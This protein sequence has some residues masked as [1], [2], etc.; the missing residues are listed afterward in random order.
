[1]PCRGLDGNGYVMILG[2]AGCYFVLNGIS[3]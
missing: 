2:V 3:S 1:M